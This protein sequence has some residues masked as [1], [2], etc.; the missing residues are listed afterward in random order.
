MI[1]RFVDGY[2]D[3]HD[4]PFRVIDVLVFDHS[5]VYPALPIT[6]VL[7]FLVGWQTGGATVSP[8]CFKSW[9]AI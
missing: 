4:K 1:T 6:G 8:S 3:A 2:T 9:P 5:V 7:L